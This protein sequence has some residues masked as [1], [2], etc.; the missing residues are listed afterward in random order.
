[1][2]TYGRVVWPEVGPKR[3]RYGLGHMLSIASATT[4]S[5]PGY[6]GKGN[7]FFCWEGVIYL[8]RQLPNGS[9][10]PRACIPASVTAQCIRLVQI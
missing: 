6:F 4:G 9:S 8:E 1:L 5:Q 10:W 7:L 2:A 3:K